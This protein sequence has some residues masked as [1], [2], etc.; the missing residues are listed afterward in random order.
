M[1]VKEIEDFVQEHVVVWLKFLSRSK[2]IPHVGELAVHIHFINETVPDWPESVSA[3]RFLTNGFRAQC[4]RCIAEENAEY[5]FLL[6]SDK[7]NFGNFVKLI[8]PIMRKS[9]SVVFYRVLKMR[10][11]LG[12]RKNRDCLFVID[13]FALGGAERSCLN[14]ANEL[15]RRGRSVD[16]CPLRG[17]FDG[18]FPLDKRIEVLTKKEILHRQYG[19]AVNYCHWVSP[20][21]ALHLVTAK[22]RI[23]WIHNDLPRI[24]G[25]FPSRKWAWSYSS[26]D[27]FVCVSESV[28]RGFA[29]VYPGLESRAVT[30]LNPY[31]V[32]AIVSHAAE[33]PPVRLEDDL[34]CV[35][36][37][38]RL[39]AAKGYS[40]AIA[41]MRSLID[42]GI[43]FRWYIVG[44][45][46]ERATLEHLIKKYGL[47][48]RFC[49][50]GPLENPFPIVA[51]ADLFAHVAHYEGYG[52]AV[53]EAV[54]LG[55]PVLA[56]DFGPAHEVLSNIGNALIVPNTLNGI[57]NGFR[58]Y[59]APGKSFMA[60]LDR[61]RVRTSYPTHI[62]FDQIE[63]ELFPEM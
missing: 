36:S 11:S 7:K 51:Q 24:F 35:V 44:E 14:L 47:T 33:V 1:D 10:A 38:G 41:A 13:R 26:F 56:T 46:K 28:L 8:A 20:M 2:K 4:F 55:L 30:I 23:Q 3:R 49:L 40:R 57:V 25:R 60:R 43:D 18:L 29:L 19:V 37:V 22:R 63:K 62:I 27:R 5:L 39:V 21:V 6:L 32:S 12:K 45:G 52:L 31:D 17:G 9:F 59:L 16:I 42:E 54:T 48:G 50:L 61:H 34:P 15:S 53:L 58:R